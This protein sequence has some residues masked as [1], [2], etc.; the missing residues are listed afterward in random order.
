MNNVVLYMGKQKLRKAAL[1]IQGHIAGKRVCV[2]VCVCIYLFF[3]YCIGAYSQLGFPGGS[4]VKES[5][6]NA[7][8]PSSIPGSGGALE[9]G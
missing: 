2:C 7:G 3:L 1:L 6:C 9:K 5:P 4:A 8:D